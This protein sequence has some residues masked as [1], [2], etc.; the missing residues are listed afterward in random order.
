MVKWVREYR[1]EGQW[2]TSMEQAAWC[3]SWDIMNYLSENT[4][5]RASA[6][7]LGSAAREGH[8]QVLYVLVNNKCTDNWSVD[9]HVLTAISGCVNKLLSKLTSRHAS[10]ASSSALWGEL[11]RV[12]EKFHK[13]GFYSCVCAMLN[14]ALQRRCVLIV[15]NYFNAR[16]ELVKQRY[17]AAAA[18]VNK[19]TLTRWMIENG[20]PLDIPTVVSLAPPQAYVRC[21]EAAGWLSK[22][23]RVALVLEGLSRRCMYEAMLL[24]VLE[25]TVFMDDN[26]GQGFVSL[27]RMLQ[28]I[29]I[30]GFSIIFPTRM[31]V[32]GAFQSEPKGISDK[33]VLAPLPG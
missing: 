18:R 7:S 2:G 3:C 24:W 29:R 31:F 25:N 8:L 22:A 28:E 15:K 17:L 13:R 11:L 27:L 30:S 23:D 32:D 1:T 21:V 14:E 19:I 33:L 10:P 26:S 6:W 9:L 5:Q 4:W 16:N 20:T 12:A